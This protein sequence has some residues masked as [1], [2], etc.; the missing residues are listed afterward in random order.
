MLTHLFFVAIGFLPKQERIIDITKNLNLN[1]LNAS[2]EKLPRKLREYPKTIYYTAPPS[3][4]TYSK[5]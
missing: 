3:I 1:A 5:I 2:N 4:T